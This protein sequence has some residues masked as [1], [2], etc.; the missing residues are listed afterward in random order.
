MLIWHYSS[1]HLF[2]FILAD[3]LEIFKLLIQ[4][5][6]NCIAHSTFNSNSVRLAGSF[7]WCAIQYGVSSL[8]SSQFLMCHLIW[9]SQFLIFLCFDG[10]FVSSCQIP[11]L[12]TFCISVLLLLM[13]SR[14]S[15]LVVG[16]EVS[17][18]LFFPSKKK[19]IVEF[20]SWL[21]AVL[22][23]I[24]C[25]LKVLQLN[26][27]ILLWNENGKFLKIYLLKHCQFL[28]IFFQRICWS[29]YFLQ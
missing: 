14:W 6:Y 2:L 20:F 9:S 25:V 11:V 23:L 16:S 13:G 26:E 3:H 29:F 1:N 19:S 7:F 18:F 15:F 24:P 8:W 17:K 10:L 28:R 5:F 22:K 12:F 27:I 21:T 4:V